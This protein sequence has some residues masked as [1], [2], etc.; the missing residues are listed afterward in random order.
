MVTNPALRYFGGK[1]KLADWILPF[2]PAHKIYYEPFGG[3]ASVLL[4][5][6]PSAIEIYN[7][8][9]NEVVD[10]FEVLRSRPQEL[11]DMLLLTPYSREEF[12][13]CGTYSGSRVED[14]RR[15]YVRSCQG[16]TF[17]GTISNSNSW[18]IQ[19]RMNKGSGVHRLC[20]TWNDADNLRAVADRLRQIY[21]EKLDAIECINR[22]DAIDALAYVDPPYL[23]STRSA[24]RYALD[25]TYHQHQSLA[26]S[27]NQCRSMVILSGYRCDEYDTWYADWKR[28]DRK[29]Q[30]G[31]V[32]T[33]TDRASAI[34]SIWIN[35]AAQS[36]LLSLF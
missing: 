29:T 7:D 27:L 20:K 14:A 3:G 10:F 18:R 21:I 19:G 32:N 4:Q 25:Y 2:F 15:F 36:K 1:W 22:F 12:D 34:E 8:L 26:E 24:T 5:K 28:V 23:H 13:R 11:I 6:Y 16:R 17:T 31:A 33:G 30:T 35:Q 9:N